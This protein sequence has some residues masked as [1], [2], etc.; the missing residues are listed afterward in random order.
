MVNKTGRLLL[1]YHRERFLNE[2]SNPH[3]TG[4]GFATLVSEFRALANP[5]KVKAPPGS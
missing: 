4:P 1:P 2:K 5:K 3:K